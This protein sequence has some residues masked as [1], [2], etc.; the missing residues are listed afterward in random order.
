MMAPIMVEGVGI[1]ERFEA[2]VGT[3]IAGRWAGTV[4]NCGG[5][6][7]AAGPGRGLPV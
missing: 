5:I 2:A 7:Y 6:E 1:R 4:Y 3:N